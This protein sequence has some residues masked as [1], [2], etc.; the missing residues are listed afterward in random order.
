MKELI[1]G[2]TTLEKIDQ[3]LNRNSS[4]TETR[5][6]AHSLGIYPDHFIKPTLLFRGHTSTLKQVAAGR[7]KSHP[8]AFG[9]CSKYLQIA[10]ISCGVN[11]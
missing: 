4:S 10:S 7:N 2:F 11:L 8:P 5:R 9:N 1:D 6:T 3:T